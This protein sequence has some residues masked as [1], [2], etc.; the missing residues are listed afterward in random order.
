MSKFH[1]FS[2]FLYI[3]SGIRDDFEAQ[4]FDLSREFLSRVKSRLELRH[5]SKG[6]KSLNFS[7]DLDSIRSRNQNFAVAPRVS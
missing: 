4:I 7:R 1:Q 5:S 6:A 2:L 3:Y